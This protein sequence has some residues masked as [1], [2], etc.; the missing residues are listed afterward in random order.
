MG[1]PLL[2]G[3]FVSFGSVRWRDDD[4]G[5]CVEQLEEPRLGVVKQVTGPRAMTVAERGP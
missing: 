2:M 3:L 5:F 4:R 1:K